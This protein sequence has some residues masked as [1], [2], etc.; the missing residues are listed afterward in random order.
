MLLARIISIIGIC[1]LFLFVSIGI[2]FSIFK[3]E[4]LTTYVLQVVI[5]ISVE[6]VGIAFKNGKDKVEN[7]KFKK[8]YPT[9]LR[10]FRAEIMAYNDPGWTPS[11]LDFAL[12]F[13]NIICL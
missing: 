4:D 13:Y 3:V 1:V 2:S 8:I 10:Y 11:D 7:P 6:L 5:A 9:Y 12:F